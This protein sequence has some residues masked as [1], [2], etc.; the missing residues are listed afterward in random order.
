MAVSLKDD[1]LS[2]FISEVE[3]SVGRLKE[4][5]A[6]GGS[7]CGSRALAFAMQAGLP[8]QM[9]YTVAQTAFYTGVDEKTLRSENRAGRINFIMPAGKE[10]GYR[11]PVGEV[12]RWMGE[13]G[14]NGKQ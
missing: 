11:V 3:E 2:T 14:R 1:P 4:A 6:E 5:L 10:R 13:Q 8:P 12:D 9:A 7:A